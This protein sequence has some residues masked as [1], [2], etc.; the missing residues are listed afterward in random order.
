[1]KKHPDVTFTAKFGD[2]S[3]QQYSTHTHGSLHRMTPERF[4][5][6]VAAFDHDEVRTLTVKPDN[7]SRIERSFRTTDIDF[8]GLKLSIFADVEVG[9]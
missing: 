8:G 5:A 6:L 1:M 3:I 2:F 7:Y 9:A 4:D